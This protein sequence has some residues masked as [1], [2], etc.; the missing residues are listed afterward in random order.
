MS[1]KNWLDGDFK[2][3]WQCWHVKRFTRATSWLKN[4]KKNRTNFFHYFR[5]CHDRSGMYLSN[6]A[7]S[8]HKL[9]NLSPS[10]NQHPACAYVEVESLVFL[11][12]VWSICCC[13]TSVTSWLNSW[14][15]S[16]LQ[17]SNR[18]RVFRPHVKVFMY[19][20]ADDRREAVI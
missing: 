2:G 15:Y 11:W 13:S 7:I 17:F 6:K 10:W 18:V 8:P 5:F 19:A 9:Y 12:L 3:R 16:S 20:C 1:T 14:L 4:S